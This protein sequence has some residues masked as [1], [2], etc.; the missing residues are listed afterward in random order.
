MSTHNIWEIPLFWRD[1]MGWLRRKKEVEEELGDL[2][3]SLVNLARH[4]GLNSENV[5]SE[6]NRKFLKRFELMEKRLGESGPGLDNASPEEM[7]RVWNKIKTRTE[8][9]CG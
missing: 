9:S 2:I 3:F 7:N 8:D 6:A 4:W 5:L 1:K